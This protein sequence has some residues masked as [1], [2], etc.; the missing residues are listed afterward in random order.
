MRYSIDMGIFGVVPDFVR[1]VVVARGVDNSR[2]V[3]ASRNLLAKAVD[4]AASAFG[5]PTGS[6]Q[7]HLAAW[8]RAYTAL[9]LDAP[10]ADQHASRAKPAS[11]SVPTLLKLGQ[12]ATPL[13]NLVQAVAIQ[14]V[15]PGGAHD[16][17]AVTGNLWLRPA[18]A[19][20]LF[21]PAT[22]P[23]RPISPEIGEIIYVDD[24]PHVLR[25]RWHGETSATARIAP[26]TQD[27]V[28]YFDCLPPLST[29]DAEEIAAQGARLI[30]GFL[31]AEIETYTLTWLQPSIRIV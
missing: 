15:V 5:A 26:D 27:A 21:V 13:V 12:P 16:L 22:A 18:R 28:I 20:E 23:E 3:S 19:T 31:H 9:G 2:N 10:P 24:G 14:R 6:E 1:A 11:Q 29:A 30:A 4:T 8:R 25:R 7:N 17:A